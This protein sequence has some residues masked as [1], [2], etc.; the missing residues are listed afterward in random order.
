MPSLLNQ[1]MDGDQKSSIF[2]VQH[3]IQGEL[4]IGQTETV[5][6]RLSIWNLNLRFSKVSRNCRQMLAQGKPF[7]GL[8]TRTY[9]T[10]L[11]ALQ[12]IRGIASVLIFHRHLLTSFYPYPEGMGI[13]G[14]AKSVLKIEWL[15]QIPILRLVYEGDF[16]TV[17]FVI[18]GYVQALEKLK[19]MD[20]QE[21]DLLQKSL[22]SSTFGRFL[23]LYGPTAAVA[24]LV[25]I[26]VKLG[27]YNWAQ[28]YRSRWLIGGPPVLTPQPALGTQFA[29]TWVS[30]Q[31][32]LD[33]WRW[34]KVYPMY[35]IPMWTIPREFRGS[36]VLYLSL[37][38]VS[39]LRRTARISALIMIAIFLLIWAKQDLCLYVFGAAL[40]DIDLLRGVHG[41]LAGLR[42]PTLVPKHTSNPTSKTREIAWTILGMIGMSLV[43]YSA[44]P[45][46]KAEGF[47]DLSFYVPSGWEAGAFWNSIGAVLVVWGIINT[48]WVHSFFGKNIFLL[49][50]QISF[51]LYLI[52][53]P[54]LSMTAHAI[55]P[56]IWE[57]FGTE[58]RTKMALGFLLPTWLIVLPILLFVSHK[59]RVFVEK[60]TNDLGRWL[61][62]S[63]FVGA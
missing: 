42:N 54:I 2:S 31:D 3:D 26:A 58:T 7:E 39:R 43:T 30:F 6:P 52:H 8:W 55:I 21:W 16:I 46:V 22:A 34:D 14:R 27:L 49:L 4:E 41:D 18:S 35:N 13:D 33:I 29:L 62:R 5:T 40:A 57:I 11:A 44:T 50:G 45:E 25:P 9:F 47:L 53:A 1:E 48:H 60:P 28:T 15:S 61:Q 56:S 36:L 32:V 23:R 12:G 38:G 20:N 63:Q 51:A 10:P 59:F 37:L 19:F 17:F 24:L